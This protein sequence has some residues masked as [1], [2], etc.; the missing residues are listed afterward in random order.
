MKQGFDLDSLSLNAAGGGKTTFDGQAKTLQLRMAGA[1]DATL[2]G[3]ASFLADTLEADVVGTGSLD[4]EGFRAAQVNLNMA[5]T[6]DVSIFASKSVTVRGAG[7]GDLTIAGNPEQ[8]SVAYVGTGTVSYK[9]L[10]A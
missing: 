8:R 7:T 10:R 4:A 5:G 9:R 6:S 2:K 3:P 1:G